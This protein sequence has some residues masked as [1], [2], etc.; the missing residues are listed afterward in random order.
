[1]G[2]E[3]CGGELAHTPV[4]FGLVRRNEKSLGNVGELGEKRR[5]WNQTRVCLG[6]KKMKTNWESNETDLACEKSYQELYHAE[7]KS[8]TGMR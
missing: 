5:G 3:M 7:K 4:Y 6:K 8:G 2:G 1:M